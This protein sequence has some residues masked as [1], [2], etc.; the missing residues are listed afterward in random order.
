[1]PELKSNEIDLPF[2]QG[3][4]DTTN[5]RYYKQKTI[6]IEFATTYS[7]LEE[8]HKTKRKLATWLTGKGELIFT[9]EINICYDAKVDKEIV[10]SFDSIKKLL[11]FT[12][13]FKCYPLGYEKIK[14]INT[15]IITQGEEKVS[16]FN[17]GNIETSPTIKLFN[18]GTT[19]V[20]NF[21]IG[22]ERLKE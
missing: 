9:D 15:K 6:K 7:N 19:T 18:V 3:T 22:I 12:V 1:M 10:F 13:E 21:S 11:R 20:N 16:I 14:K 5:K 8:L 17:A 2:S 4:L